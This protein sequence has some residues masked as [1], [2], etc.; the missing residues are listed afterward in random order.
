MIL[1]GQEYSE[2]QGRTQKGALPGLYPL[3]NLNVKEKR[4]CIQDDI[5]LLRDFKDEIN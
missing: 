5:K 3:S 1:T 2:Y 4:F